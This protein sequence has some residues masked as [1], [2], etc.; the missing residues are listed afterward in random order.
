MTSRV[1]EL[2]RETQH[3]PS[4]DEWRRR[5]HDELSPPIDVTTGKECLLPGH[6]KDMLPCLLATRDTNHEVLERL[7]GLDEQDARRVKWNLVLLD[8]QRRH[9]QPCAILRWDQTH[10]Q[11][12]QS[13]TRVQVVVAY[14]FVSLTPACHTALFA[15]IQT[16]HATNRLSL[17][18]ETAYEEAGV[19]DAQIELLCARAVD[20][21]RQQ[22]R[23]R[24]ASI[25]REVRVRLNI[26]KP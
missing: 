4:H 14:G 16:F 7:L 3:A 6:M 24:R 1:L 23:E 21:S 5:T 26:P 20:D 12:A 2:G 10:T 22:A 15:H 11:D 19:S 13:R 9:D 8:L 18:L 25:E 17:E